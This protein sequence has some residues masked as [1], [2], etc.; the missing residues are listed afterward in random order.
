MGT[1]ISTAVVFLMTAASASAALTG[2]EAKRLAAA[3]DIIRDIQS[4]I[5][6]KLWTDARCVA[7]IPDLK[8]AAFVFGGE[9]GRGVMSCRNADDRWSPPIFMTLA[10]GSWGLQ[11]GAEEVDVVLLAMN[12]HAQQKLL[13]NKLTLGA[14]VSIAAG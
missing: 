7:V 2:N 13:E 10:K 1:S 5:P 12:E 4:N 9:F 14:D 6:P 8:K 3:S 11:I